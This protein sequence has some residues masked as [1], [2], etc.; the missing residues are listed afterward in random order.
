VNPPIDNFL[1]G[2]AYVWCE[3]FYKRAFG[4]RIEG[5]EHIPENGRVIV[6]SNHISAW[7]PPFVA[8]VI[9][10]RRIAH[11]PAKIEVF[12]NPI[13]RWGLGKL[14]SFPL[15][16][17]KADLGAMRRSLEM[18]ESES[19]LGIYPE[20][21]RSRTGELLPAK[22]GVGYL[23]AESGAPVVPARVRGIVR[24]PKRGELSMRLGPPLRF[25]E[26]EGETK[27]K[28]GYRLFA[29]RVMSAISHL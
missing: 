26:E 13:M 14:H 5:L 23:A 2:L 16:R 17:S 15:D 3:L 27:S 19:C 20:G 21:T 12:R 25:G 11:F 10:H 6:A 4:A 29:K 7:D 24:M 8:F 1:Y 9:G 22:P 28:E 18:L